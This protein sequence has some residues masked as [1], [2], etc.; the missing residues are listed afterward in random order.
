MRDETDYL[1]CEK[2]LRQLV[3]KGQEVKDLNCQI[4]LQGQPDCEDCRSSIPIT[5]I[6]KRSISC[7]ACID[8]YIAANSNKGGG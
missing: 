1:D 8:D 4:C 3:K 7:Q 6:K 5:G 2:C